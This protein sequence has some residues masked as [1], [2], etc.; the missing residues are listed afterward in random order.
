FGNYIAMVARCLMERMRDLSWRALTERGILERANNRLRLYRILA[1]V[2]CLIVRLRLYGCRRLR[3]FL[4]VYH[5]MININRVRM[6]RL[7]RICKP[8][9]LIGLGRLV[10]SGWGSSIRMGIARVA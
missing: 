3:L 8:I 9:Y 7:M 2:E 6:F 4:C 1:L 5:D 10:R